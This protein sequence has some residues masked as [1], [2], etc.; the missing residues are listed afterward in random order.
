MMPP[1]EVLTFIAGLTAILVLSAWQAGVLDI[2]VKDVLK[3]LAALIFALGVH[4][5]VYGSF[6][7]L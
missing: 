4:T 7:P 2:G 3:F 1:I 6:T 5:L